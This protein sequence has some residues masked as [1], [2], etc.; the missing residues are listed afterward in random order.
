MDLS[1]E[2]KYQ[3]RCFCVT[4][5]PDTSSGI[6]NNHQSTLTKIYSSGVLPQN[7]APEGLDQTCLL[8]TQREEVERTEIISALLGTLS[9]SSP[10]QNLL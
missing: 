10:M 8:P 5:L 2:E 7:V 4:T 3:E 1:I 9:G 6:T